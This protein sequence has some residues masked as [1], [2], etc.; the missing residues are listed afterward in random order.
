MRSV[1]SCGCFD[2]LGRD[3]GDFDFKH[4]VSDLGSLAQYFCDE[5]HLSGHIAKGGVWHRLDFAAHIQHTVHNIEVGAR[6]VYS[7]PC[8]LCSCD[9]LS[10]K[11][12]LIYHDSSGV[13]DALGCTTW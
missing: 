9:P 1:K 5:S 3:S 12:V 13:P 6:N 4:Q 2:R 11:V 10:P 8:K 7:A